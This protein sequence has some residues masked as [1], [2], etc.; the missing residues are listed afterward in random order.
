MMPSSSS[1]TSS[2]GWSRESAARGGAQGNGRGDRTGDRGGPG[3][4]RRVRA[5]AFIG[6]VT[7]QFFRQFA[8]TIAVS[9]V[10]SAFNSL[11]LSPALAVLLLKL[12]GGRR[13]PLTWLL[14]TALGWFFWLFNWLFGD[15]HRPVRAVGGRPA[16]RQP[17]RP[18]RLRRPAGAD[19]FPLRQRPDRLHPAAG[20][21]LSAPQRPA[22]RLRLRGPYTESHGPH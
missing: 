6:G 3:A 1:R 20:Q 12:R 18:A 13:D 7:G 19:V 22:I 21:G 9:T 16:A 10:I 15:R 4:V 17:D 5:L 2:A 11:T 8:V 14:D